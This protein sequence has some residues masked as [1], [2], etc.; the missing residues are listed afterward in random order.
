MRTYNSNQSKTSQRRSAKRISIPDRVAAALDDRPHAL[1]QREIQSLQRLAGNTAV[2]QLLQRRAE[3]RSVPIS[4]QRDCIPGHQG[5]ADPIYE[6]NKASAHHY[7]QEYLS[8]KKGEKNCDVES[9]YD[10]VRYRPAP[11]SGKKTAPV[12]TDDQ[13]DVT[14]LGP[15]THTVLPDKHQVI[16]TTTDK[17]RLH[18]GQVRITVKEKSDGVYTSYEGFGTGSMGFLNEFFSYPLWGYQHGQVKKHNSEKL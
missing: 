3:E 14:G 2:V 8:C 6:Q 9:I 17:H 1:G 16:N 5:A 7:F 10:S 11:G 12:K 15:V 13:T 18:K 4:V